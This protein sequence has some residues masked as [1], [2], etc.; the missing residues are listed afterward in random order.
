MILH[1]PF[2]HEVPSL[3]A[4]NESNAFLRDNLLVSRLSPDQLTAS[5]ASW[6]DVR[7]V[8]MAHV[9]ALEHEKAGG[10]RF[11]AA[12][13]GAFTFQEMRTSFLTHTTIHTRKLIYSGIQLM[14]YTQHQTLHRLLPAAPL[15]ASHYPYAAKATAVARRQNTSSRFISGV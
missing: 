14:H 13:P 2:I 5:Q 9:S 6:V 12:A 7:D 4:L 8:A 11:L 1:Q 10:E 3:S 15:A